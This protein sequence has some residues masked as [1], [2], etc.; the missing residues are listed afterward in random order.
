VPVHL[1]DYQPNDFDTL[2][3]LDQLCFPEDIAYSRSELRIFLSLRTA[4]C[5]VAEQDHNIAGFVVVDSRPRRAGYIV[6]IDVDPEQRRQGIASILLTE[7]ER[8]LLRQGINAI[9]LEVADNNQ[10]ARDFYARHGF[11]IIG[12]KPGY[13]NGRVDA[14]SLEKK[15]R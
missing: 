12:R 2:W 15:L 4:F 10:S 8:R 14:L 3:K 11:V 5:I 1:R 9:R 7:V 13:Y 6:T